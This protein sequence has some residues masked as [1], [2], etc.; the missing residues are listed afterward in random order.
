MTTV[1]AMAA[2]A[3]GSCHNNGDNG[4]SSSRSMADQGEQEGGQVDTKR[5]PSRR[6]GRLVCMDEGGEGGRMGRHKQEAK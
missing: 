3:A 5:R 1:A 2:A 6:E 4:I